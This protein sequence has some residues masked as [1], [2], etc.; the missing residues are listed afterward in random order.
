MQLEAMA[1]G[2]AISVRNMIIPRERRACGSVKSASETDRRALGR[3][4]LGRSREKIRSTLLFDVLALFS[5]SSATVLV[6]P[7]PQCYVCNA[8]KQTR[9]KRETTR[10]HVRSFG[11]VLAHVYR[12]DRNSTG[13]SRSER[14]MNSS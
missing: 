6:A 14:T 8:A 3:I 2:I 10:R 7:V 12:S 4:V 11:R 5:F 13:L 1:H 9:F